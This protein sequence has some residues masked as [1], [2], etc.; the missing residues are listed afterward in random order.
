[1]K[2]KSLEY[3]DVIERNKSAL[4]DYLAGFSSEDQHRIPT[5]GKWSALMIV[6][7]IMLAEA[8]SLAYCKKKLSF[9][10]ELAEATEEEMAMETKVP[11]ILRSPKYKNQAPPGIDTENLDNTR[12]LDSLYE[13]WDALRISIKTFLDEQPEA[14]YTKALYKHPLAGKMRL[15]GMVMFY[16]GHLDSHTSQIKGQFERMKM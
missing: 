2:D 15:Q 1:M 13:E 6:H 7:H 16:D 5:D 10:P 14:L 8:G 4:K 3:F 9:N 12:S 11:Y